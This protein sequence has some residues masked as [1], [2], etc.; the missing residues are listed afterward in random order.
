MRT[1]GLFQKE[2]FSEIVRIRQEKAKPILDALYLHLQDLTTKPEGT[3][4]LEKQ[5]DIQSVNGTNSYY[6]YLM[7]KF[8]HTPPYTS[9]E[10]LSR[11]VV[12]CSRKKKLALFW[13]TCWCFCKCI[14]VFASSNC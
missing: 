7:A 10:N 1:L 13:F 2:M 9:C 4:I 6:I 14:Q 8:T 11:V 12:P 3:L 5:D